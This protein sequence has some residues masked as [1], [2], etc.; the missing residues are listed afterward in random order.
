MDVDT[1][2]IKRLESL[3]GLACDDRERE[4]LRRDL[5]HM[6]DYVER[7]ETYVSGCDPSPGVTA[8]P[9]RRRADEPRHSLT[10]AEAQDGA[11]A[12]ADGCFLCPP[13]RDGD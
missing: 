8:N 7:L 2:L 4:R 10:T 5:G 11:P 6:L 3:T 9:D 13:I 12:V 1:A